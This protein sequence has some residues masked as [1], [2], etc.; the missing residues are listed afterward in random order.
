M[1]EEALWWTV[2]DCGDEEECED[3]LE[4]LFEED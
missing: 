2:V 3:A 1:D 4:E